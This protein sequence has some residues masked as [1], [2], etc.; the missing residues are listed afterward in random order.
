[1]ELEGHALKTQLIYLIVKRKY[2][3]ILKITSSIYLYL[4]VER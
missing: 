4:I 2:Y 1:M 3:T